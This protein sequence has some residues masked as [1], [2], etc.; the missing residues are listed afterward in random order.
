MGRLPS[1]LPVRMRRIEI[2]G[3]EVAWLPPL[4][5]IARSAV[6]DDRITFSTMAVA[7]LRLDVECDVHAGP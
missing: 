6:D 2:K 4:Q 3:A 1:Q 5:R 7:M